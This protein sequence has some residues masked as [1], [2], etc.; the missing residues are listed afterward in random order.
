MRRSHEILDAR[1]RRVPA[2]KLPGTRRGQLR[3][4]TPAEVDRMALKCSEASGATKQLLH[5]FAA[6]MFVLLIFVVI[7]LV[8]RFDLTAVLFALVHIL[9][10]SIVFRAARQKSIPAIPQHEVTALLLAEG[11]CPSCAYR[12]EPKRLEPDGHTI[13]SECGAAWTLPP[14]RPPEETVAFIEP[15][16]AA[17]LVIHHWFPF[18][19]A[20]ADRTI[21]D[22]KGHRVTLFPILRRERWRGGLSDARWRTISYISPRLMT[23]YILVGWCV[24]GITLKALVGPGAPYRGVVPE[25]LPG[26]TFT[27]L[28]VFAVYFV[29][30]PPRD[31]RRA[32]VTLQLGC[33]PSCSVSLNSAI[34]PQG[35]HVCSACAA[36]WHPADRTRLK[37]R[38]RLFGSRPPVVT[39]DHRG[40]M[41]PIFDAEIFRPPGDIPQFLT[42]DA[43]RDLRKELLASD[44]YAAVNRIGSM[45]L[46]IC[47]ASV[48]VQDIRAVRPPGI[49]ACLLF[50]A[51]V[52]WTLRACRGLGNDPR[53]IIDSL[54]WRT[55][56]GSCGNDLRALEPAD[57]GCTLCPECG[58]AWKLRSTP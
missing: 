20:T 32:C 27:V 15:I 46:I 4:F 41:H 10:A 43:W 42:K 34:D 19:A 26:V 11:H 22:A 30:G 33:C 23:P 39:A 52:L 13:C 25:W 17:S 49:M 28:T 38:P 29:W 54:L 5:V 18:A 45:A 55:R 36:S 31:A 58:A 21:T 6:I 56:C 40:I 7:R 44:W 53:R 35:H 14:P 12:L 37:L 8:G 3:Y 51:S 47:V 57:D 48:I 50:V 24:I 1:D 16:S 2:F 9:L